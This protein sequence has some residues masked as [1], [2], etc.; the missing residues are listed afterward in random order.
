MGKLLTQSFQRFAVA[1]GDHFDRPILQ[2][3]DEAHEAQ[4]TTVDDDVLVEAIWGDIRTATERFR[5][6]WEFNG[7][8]RGTTPSWACI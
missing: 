5:G 1:A 7:R 4:P 8:L 3:P 6:A 2:I